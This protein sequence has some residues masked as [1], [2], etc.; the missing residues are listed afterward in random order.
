MAPPLAK[1]VAH[2]TENTAEI[3]IKIPLRLKTKLYIYTSTRL[4]YLNPQCK[5]KIKTIE[6]GGF[7]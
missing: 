6:N 4:I 5:L 3:Y 1:R 2:A 7:L